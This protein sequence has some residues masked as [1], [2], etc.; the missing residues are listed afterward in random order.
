LLKNKDLNHKRKRHKT[1]RAGCLMCKPQKRGGLKDQSQMYHK[2]FG[3]LRELIAANKE[4]KDS[5]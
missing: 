5:L 2:G 4:L 1:A 3:K